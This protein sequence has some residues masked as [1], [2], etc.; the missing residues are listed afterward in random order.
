MSKFKESELDLGTIKSGSNIVFHFYSI[1]DISNN[2]SYVESG[3]G[4][5]TKVL[6]Y[7]NGSL[8][9]KFSSGTFP[10]HID[11]DRYNINKSVYVHYKDGTQEELRFKGLILK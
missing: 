1:E 6:G 3:C 4:S 10:F 5:C 9:I 11:N 2:I 8:S 7:Q